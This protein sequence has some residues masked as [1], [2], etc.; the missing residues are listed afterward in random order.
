MSLP[1]AVSQYVSP[2]VCCLSV[3]LP[4][5]VGV[6]VCLPWS[7]VW[8]AGLVVTDWLQVPGCGENPSHDLVYDETSAACE[9]AKVLRKMRHF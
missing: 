2:G 4:D 8:L 5:L 9:V 1:E 6:Q 3:S 7:T